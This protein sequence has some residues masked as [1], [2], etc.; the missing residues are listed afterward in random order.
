MG[1]FFFLMYFRILSLAPMTRNVLFL[2]RA[3]VSGLSRDETI[4]FFFSLSSSECEIDRLVRTR[5][6]VVYNRIMI[7]RKDNQSKVRGRKKKLRSSESGWRNFEH[8]RYE[9]ECEIVSR[10]K[11]GQ[12]L[13]RI[14]FSRYNIK[15]IRAQM[16]HFSAG[17]ET[18]LWFMKNMYTQTEKKST[19]LVWTKREW[20]KWIFQRE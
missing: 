19:H 1:V 2:A 7:P 15:N 3:R 16:L 11:R 20:T 9:V 12:W 10:R 5:V 18:R 4:T 6:P 13:S 8:P 17:I 14:F